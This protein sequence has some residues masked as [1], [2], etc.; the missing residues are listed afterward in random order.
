MEK[1]DLIA[2][3]DEA[4]YMMKERSVK[5]KKH[6]MFDTPM[7]YFPPVMGDRNRLRQVFINIIDN[8]LKYSDKE[9]VV[10]VNAEETEG[11]VI[12]TIAD[13][14]CGISA[15]DLPKVK[16][17]FYKANQTVRGSGIGLAVADEIIAMH[18]GSMDITSE[19][20]GKGTTV[21]ITLPAK[22]N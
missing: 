8:A 3:L 15:K 9:G 7:E 16:Q 12:I 2:E 10:T 6:L 11:Q 4:V 5:E 14:G 1:T 18:G 17:K 13:N 21:T 22:S 20:E 19:G